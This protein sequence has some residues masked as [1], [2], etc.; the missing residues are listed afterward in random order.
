MPYEASGSSSNMWYSFDYGL[1]HFINFD[2]ETDFEGAPEG[3]GTHLNS[4]PFTGPAGTQL[5]WLRKDLI[6][7]HA[8]RDKVPWIMAG[9]H[10]PFYSGHTKDGV[11]I[12][13]RDAFEPLFNEF[14]VDL[15]FFGHIHWTERMYALAPNGTVLQRDYN[16]PKNPIYIISASV[17]N[18]EGLSK[19]INLLNNITLFLDGEHYGI[20]RLH[21]ANR[22]HC[23]WR[24]ILSETGEAKDE[25]VIYKAHDNMKIVTPVIQQE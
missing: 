19:P 7:A 12:P 25:A 10:R 5:E 23:I 22:T 14:Q 4:G 24:W 18:V 20:G 9:G 1:V 21:V 8:N 3:V 17:G 15:V 2:T 6:K 13:S 11:H 16:N